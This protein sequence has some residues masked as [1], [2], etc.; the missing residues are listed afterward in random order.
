[1]LEG[2]ELIVATKQFVKENKVRSWQETL[3]TF[4]LLVF[5][6]VI[7]F[8][9]DVLWVRIIGS[10]LC[11]LT[12]VRFFV[13]FHDYMHGTILNKSKLA[14]WLFAAFGIFILAPESIWKRS[15]DY[16][17]KHNSKLFSTSIG[18]FPIITKEQF[19]NATKQERFLYLF[20]RHPLT[21]MLGYIFVFFYG[22]TILSF[23]RNPSKH[24]DSLV[25][26]IVHFLCYVVV[27][28]FFGLSGILLGLIIPFLISC[29]IGSYL[30]Y[31]QHN[32]PTA[33][34]NKNEKWNYYE[35]AMESSSY[36]KT[37]AVMQWFTANIGFHHIHHINAR[38][39]FYRLPEA[40][41]SM[42]EF[43]NAKTIT[44]KLSD[45][46]TCFRLKLWDPEKG[47]MITLKEL[48]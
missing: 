44:L 5:C 2:K 4:A 12:I 41:K 36:M 42:V 30:F 15:H 19:M 11:G 24:W 46:I 6:Y 47:K 37:N 28:Y 16:H 26:M 7:I 38:I 40:Q 34:F 45:I 43:Q 1:M 35:A 9:V 33:T 32:F 27:Y 20:V 39:P 22:M 21:I 25:S 13:I 3:V 14:H 18:S 8:S 23:S 10:V 48:N 29:G 17:H 31:I